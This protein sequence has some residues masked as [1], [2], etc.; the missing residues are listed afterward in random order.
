[1][2]NDAGLPR[3]AEVVPRGVGVDPYHNHHLLP[4]RA[5]AAEGEARAATLSSQ[6]FS[7]ASTTHRPDPRIGRFAPAHHRSMESIYS[8]VR[9]PDAT[10]P[11]STRWEKHTSISEVLGNQGPH[12][13][14]SRPSA[15]LGQPTA[16]ISSITPAHDQSQPPRNQPQHLLDPPYPL[17]NQSHPPHDQAQSTE[18]QPQDQLDPETTSAVKRLSLLLAAANPHLAGRSRDGGYRMSQEDARLIANTFRTTLTRPMKF[19][20]SW[21]SVASGILASLPEDEDGDGSSG[22]V[23]ATMA[24]LEGHVGGACGVPRRGREEIGHLELRRGSSGGNSVGSWGG[25]GSGAG[26]GSRLTKIAEE[27]GGSDRDVADRWWRSQYANSIT[28]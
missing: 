28:N 9:R 13:N 23:T 10:P 3:F 22:G 21:Y 2:H 15:Q 5:I 16:N 7:S 17:H 11:P 6:R 1:M 26:G 8:S 20:P 24:K 18:D 19:I 25:N 27:S 14:E 12:D 4:I